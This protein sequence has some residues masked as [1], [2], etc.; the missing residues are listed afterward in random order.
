MQGQVHRAKA[1]ET[2]DLDE[3][4]VSKSLDVLANSHHGRWMGVPL[5]LVATS[6]ARCRRLV[7]AAVTLAIGMAI[8][9]IHVANDPFAFCAHEFSCAITRQIEQLRRGGVV[10]VHLA[11]PPPSLANRTVLAVNH[12]PKA[13]GTFVVHATVRSIGHDFFLDIHEFESSDAATQRAM[14]VIGEVCE[15]CSATTTPL[16]C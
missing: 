9:I 14:F 4:D 11:P 13:G 12:N 15:P 7:V 10:E 3:E 1:L 16:S 8:A 2:A 6:S 5:D